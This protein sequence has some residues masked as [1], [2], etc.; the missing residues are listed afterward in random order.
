MHASVKNRRSGTDRIN[1]ILDLVRGIIKF[2][3][4]STRKLLNIIKSGITKEKININ[5]DFNISEFME[6]IEKHHIS[7]MVYNGIYNCIVTISE[8]YKNILF[9]NALQEA[10]INGK[11][12]GLI[13]DLRTLFNNNKIDYVFLKGSVLKELYPTPETRR[14]GDIDV[15]IRVE[16]YEKIRKVLLDNGYQEL[17]ETNHE[18]KWQK[19]RILIELHKTLMPTYNIDFH[20]YFGNGWK[21][22]KCKEQYEYDFNNEDKFIFL[23][24]H[25]AKH[26]RDAG[27]GIIHICDLYLYLSKINLDFTYID[28][29]LKE[30]N[31][32]KFYCNI[33]SVLNVWFENANST[34]MTDY[35]TDVILN[36][37][38]Y[39][40]YDNKVISN[41]LKR[42][43]RFNSYKKGRIYYFIRLIFPTYESMLQKYPI[44][45]RCPLLLPFMWISRIF[46][47]IFK[48]RE[49]INERK[50]DISIISDE[51][52]DNYN[53]H[54]KYVGLK[55]DF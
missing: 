15:L 45:K 7:T 26:Y 47:I 25:F 41:E 32:Y 34:E 3:D 12:L 48:D 13:K 52:V 37:G 39:G 43:Q 44:L 16:Q 31:L 5:T 49:R 46:R 35:I 2:M 8:K 55:Y 17:G 21:L 53:I 6:L 14:M 51:K 54:L 24:T 10:V 4:I 28:K 33:K 18:L 36:S 30:L 27:I 42:K 20:S 40:R 38:V 11:Q 29:Q 9:K 23:F 22:V 19:D 50:N 1:F